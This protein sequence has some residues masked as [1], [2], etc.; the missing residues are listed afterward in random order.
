LSQLDLSTIPLLTNLDC[1]NNQLSSLTLN[2]DTF[3]LTNLN[4]SDNQIISLDLSNCPNIDTFFCSNNQLNCLNIKNDNNT[5]ISHFIATGNPDLT[6]IEV[7]DSAWSS[8]N[9]TSLNGNIDSLV[10]FSTFCNN[11]CSSPITDINQQ[12]TKFNI[13]PNPFNSSVSI[14][15]LSEPHVLTIYDLLGNK[16][17][18]D[19]VNGTTVI[20]R[21]DLLK[22]V[23]IIDVRSKSRMNSAKLVVE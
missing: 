6:C 1:S 20:E 22:G 15:L 16:L 12:K 18:E 13:Y 3:F 19:Q 5:L 10:Y 23:Y 17:R 9:W 11:A 8:S 2:T 7:D 4:I 14:E 21:G